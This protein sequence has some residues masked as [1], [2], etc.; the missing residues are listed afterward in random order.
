MV[1]ECLDLGA[2]ALCVLRHAL[3]FRFRRRLMLGSFLGLFNA[4]MMGVAVLR[5]MSAFLRGFGCSYYFVIY[6]VGRF[7]IFVRVTR[8]I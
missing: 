7:F 4:L 8:I 1:L 6:I 5:L 3:A 2:L